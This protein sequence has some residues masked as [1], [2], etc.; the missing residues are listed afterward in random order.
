MVLPRLYVRLLHL[1]C[2]QRPVRCERAFCD[3]ARCRRRAEMQNA[4]PSVALSALGGAG[5]H[6]TSVAL[7]WQN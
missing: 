5:H 4:R 6:V 1:A 7:L 2:E 3:Y